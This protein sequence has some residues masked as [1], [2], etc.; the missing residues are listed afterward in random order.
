MGWYLK[1][2][3]ILQCS[4]LLYLSMVNNCFTR[5]YDRVIITPFLFTVYKYKYNEKTYHLILCQSTSRLRLHLR[6]R[7]SRHYLKWFAGDSP[8]RVYCICSLANS[9]KMYSANKPAFISVVVVWLSD[10]PIFP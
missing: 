10:C 4:G 7:E 6:L 1:S 3:I 9:I 8:N 2:K 5:R